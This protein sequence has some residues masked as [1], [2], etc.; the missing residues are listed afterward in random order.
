MDCAF[1]IRWQMANLRLR[2]R[3]LAATLLTVTFSMTH[4][5]SYPTRPIRIIVCPGPDVLAR[6]IGQQITEDWGQQV[7]VEQQP[8]A[9]GIIAGDTVAKATPDGYTGL[10]STGSYTINVTLHPKLSYNFVR[11]L[12]PVSLLATIPFL[13]VVNP[14]LAV[15]SVRELLKLARA[16]PGQLNCASSGTGTTAHLACEMFRTTPAAP[17]LPT[18]AESGIAGFRVLSWNGLHVPARTPKAIIKKLNGELGKIVKSPEIRAR[19]VELGLEPATDTPEDFAVFVKE[20]IERW[21]KVI[22]EAHVHLE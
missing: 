9:G 4:A 1:F 8:G 19:M 13:L 22:K 16:K 2:T 14:S 6:L 10:L 3:I 5:Q 12:A 7:V 15:H 20:D 18:V 11:D 17:E 21:A